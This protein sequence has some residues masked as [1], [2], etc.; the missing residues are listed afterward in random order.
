VIRNNGIASQNRI[1]PGGAGTWLT[2]TAMTATGG[3]GFA[4]LNLPGSG[5]EVT[6]T[7]PL[8]SIGNPTSDIGLAMLIVN[9]LGRSHVVPATATCPAPC[10]KRDLT[11]VTFPF[12]DMP[13]SNDP[14]LDP[15]VI[16]ATT[17]GPPWTQPDHWGRGLFNAAAGSNTT[18][19]F[20][21]SPS[22]YFSSSLKLGICNVGTWAQITPAVD[23]SQNL[24]N[25]YKYEADAPCQMGVWVKLSNTGTTAANARLLVLWA[26]GGLGV[27]DWRVVELTPPINFGPG[28]STHR[29]IWDKVPHGGSSPVNG[30][31]A[32]LKAFVL[33]A[34]L[35]ALDPVTNVAQTE[36]VIAAIDNGSKVAAFQRAYGLTTDTTPRAGQMN[37]S[38]LA[39]GNCSTPACSQPVVMLEPGMGERATAWLGMRTVFAQPP[40]P[41]QPPGDR[42]INAIPVDRDFDDGAKPSERVTSFLVVLDAYAVPQTATPAD[43]PYVFLEPVGGI[44]WAV[45]YSMVQ[46]APLALEFMVGNPPTLYEDVV[47]RPVTTI[48]TPARRIMFATR[49]EAPAGRE[50]PRVT[51]RPLGKEALEPGETVKA[52][53]DVPQTAGGGA[54]GWQRWWWII[55]LI[56][57]VL[58]VIIWLLR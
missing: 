20:S 40:P 3:I 37:F 18:L 12:G 27:S 8:N 31:H 36:A 44:A 7:I 53:I 5:Y 45:P 6:L 11:A 17:A 43:R 46:S 29:V 54:G 30:S 22:F 49:V 13:A 25:W 56:L 21:H 4:T 52:A 32:C 16:N 55:L 48:A 50:A 34:T 15:G 42:V 51:L 35:G 39:T 28:Q 24:A 58:V 47:R 33:P 57:L 41:V 9:D 19:S 38:N 10:L 14:F 26:D 2:A 23:L 1:R